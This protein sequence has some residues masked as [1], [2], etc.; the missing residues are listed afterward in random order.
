MN[1]PDIAWFNH[2]A[3]EFTSENW[4]SPDT[5]AIGMYLAGAI[6][7]GI[8]IDVVDNGFYYFL[9]SGSEPITVTLPSGQYASSYRLMF[10]TADERD[11]EKHD[12]IEPGSTIELKPWS[13]ALWMITA[14]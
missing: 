11:W 13:S 1:V 10:N 4:E 2:D 12:H 7:D 6:S 14:R 9:N 3:T 5:R 8:N